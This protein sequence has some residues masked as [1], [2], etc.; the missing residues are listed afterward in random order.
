MRSTLAGLVMF[1]AVVAAQ[2][3]AP[4]LDASATSVDS[5]IKNYNASLAAAEQARLA[6]MP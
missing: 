4:I 3:Q 2:E 5:L 1:S 6:L